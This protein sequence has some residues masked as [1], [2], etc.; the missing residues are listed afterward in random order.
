MMK[1][2]SL[3]LK[4]IEFKRQSFIKD[5]YNPINFLNK[6]SVIEFESAFAFIKSYE[7]HYL[8][9]VG[10]IWINIASVD[11]FENLKRIILESDISSMCNLSL[12]VHDLECLKHFDKLED[13]RFTLMLLNSYKDY[14]E[15][16]P[17][18]LFKSRNMLYMMHELTYENV[19]TM[20]FDIIESYQKN[21]ERFIYL[22]VDYESFE[23]HASLNDLHN[24]FFR[25]N[26]FVSFCIVSKEIREIPNTNTTNTN[27]NTNRTFDMQYV[28]PSELNH[29]IFVSNDLKLYYNR[30]HYIEKEMPE[31]FILQKGNGETIELREL[32]VLRSYMD[33]TINALVLPNKRLNIFMVDFY[34][35]KK[36]MGTINEVPYI[37]ELI[38]RWL[39][40]V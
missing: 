2:K 13:K 26:R 24:I 30:K 39:K 28:R 8:S 14:T 35:N 5:L 7:E 21:K 23:K 1:K 32:N 29:R 11:E 15:L 38:M 20:F 40:Y 27:R 16:E 37:T 17:F 25:I 3:E 22:T 9:L 4:D 19:N 31:L 18:M 36:I 12:V 34:Q 6:F 33:I 10:D